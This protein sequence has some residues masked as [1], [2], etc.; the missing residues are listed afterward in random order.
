MMKGD[1]HLRIMLERGATIKDIVEEI[2]SNQEGLDTDGLVL[3]LW[4]K[5]R[6]G[7][8]KTTGIVRVSKKDGTLHFLVKENIPE[9]G[10]RWREKQRYLS[11]GYGTK[12]ADLR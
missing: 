4:L 3:P 6:S 12:V 11:F 1:L 9:Y 2:V 8:T 7:I 10:M 5:T